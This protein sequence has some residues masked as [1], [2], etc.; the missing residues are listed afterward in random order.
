MKTSNLLKLELLAPLV[1]AEDRGLDPF[2]NRRDKSRNPPAESAGD[3]RLFCFE[4]GAGQG[5]RIE[6]DPDLF[7]GSLTFSGR[8]AEPADYAGGRMELPAGKYLFAQERRILNR[9]EC[10]FMA[11]ETQKDGLWER[12]RPESGLYLR[13]LTE[14][15]KRVTQTFRPYGEDERGL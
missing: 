15:G 10:V 1:Y 8:K 5:D 2:E 4:I 6:P 9:D 14:D 11:I 3:D 12:L 7:L 13:F